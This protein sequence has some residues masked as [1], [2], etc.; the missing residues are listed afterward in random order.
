MKA[1]NLIATIFIL[2]IAFSLLAQCP[3][4]SAAGLYAT[5]YRMI[6]EIP[7]EDE[8]ITDSRCYFPS[9]GSGIDPDAV[10]CPIIVFGHGFMTSVDNYFSYAE[11]YA[12]WGYVCIVPTYSNPFLFSNH[13][14]RARLL[15][16]SAHYIMALNSESGDIFQDKLDIEKLALVGHSMGGSIS[17]LAGD[18]YVNDLGETFHLDDTLC[19]IIAFGSPQS[20]PETEPSNITTP[21]MFLSAT[22]DNIAPWEEVREDLWIGS[23]APGAFAVIDGG[24]HTFF[25][26]SYGHYISDG[27]ATITREEQLAIARKHS[28][29]FLQMY[30]RADTSECVEDF[31]YGD[32]LL[33]ASWID[34]SEIRYYSLSID[35]DETLLR[36]LDVDIFPNPFDS[37]VFIQTKDIDKAD[38][39]VFDISGKSI[40][41]SSFKN[42]FEWKPKE[43]IPPGSYIIIVSGG[44]LRSKKVANYLY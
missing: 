29:A 27:T 42:C 10:P 20:S 18:M 22:E 39:E 35:E 23:S 40:F 36:Q 38:I 37:K 41:K 19:C 1:I 7:T 21:Y 28:T 16:T 43:K 4:F 8:T 14:Y 34:S 12:S 17:L 13:D 30:I 2:L 33:E 15:I 11:H 24:N 9:N 44:N 25:T 6:D 26:D 3:D 5:D 31:I 32:S